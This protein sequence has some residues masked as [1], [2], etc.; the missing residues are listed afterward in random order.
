MILITKTTQKFKLKS[1]NTNKDIKKGRSIKD[2]IL[3]YLNPTSINLLDPI[4]VLK[5]KTN[6]DII[7]ASAEPIIPYLGINAQFNPIFISAQKREY[8]GTY[9]TAFFVQL[10]MLIKKKYKPLNTYP[11]DMKGITFHAC[12]Y[13]LFINKYITSGENK[14]IHTERIP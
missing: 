1:I 4:Y 9:L 13:P 12:T 5:L 8:I 11:N 3:L 6:I 2:I 10:K 7:V 14:E